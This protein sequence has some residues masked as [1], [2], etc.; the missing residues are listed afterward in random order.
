VRDRS[1]GARGE[2]YKKAGRQ[3][4]Q[5]RYM[6]RWPLYTG[7]TY[8]VGKE[9]AKLSGIRDG[10]RVVKKGRG[11]G[12]KEGGDEAED[13]EGRGRA[14][15]SKVIEEL[16]KEAFGEGSE[17]ARMGCGDNGLG[18]EGSTLVGGIVRYSRHANFVG[19]VGI[20]EVVRREMRVGDSKGDE[21]EQA[22]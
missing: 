1:K 15:L 4:N 13:C 21:C 6:S 8:R 5:F 20:G 19:V 16:G 17:R 12:S 11:D 10:H 18:F 7:E 2:N 14:V 22:W 9:R 3:A